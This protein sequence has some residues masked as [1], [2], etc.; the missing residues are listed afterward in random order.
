[1]DAHNWA[2]TVIYGKDLRQTSATLASQLPVSQMNEHN[3]S[4]NIAFDGNFLA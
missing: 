1:L 2:V 4:K 3:F